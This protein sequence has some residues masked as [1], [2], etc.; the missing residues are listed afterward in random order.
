MKSRL[1]ATMA[2]AVALGLA[3]ETRAQSGP[4]GSEADGRADLRTLLGDCPRELLREAWDD[5]EALETA[6]VEVEV[7]T[8]CTERAEAIARLLDAQ[9]RLDGALAV[10]R[11]TVPTPSAVLATV[12]DDRVERLRDEIVSL[13]DRI[14]RLEGE[15]EGAETESTLAELRGDLATAEADLARMEEADAAASASPADLLPPG[16]DGAETGISPPTGATPP[17]MSDG[18]ETVDDVP[19]PVM[20]P[21]SE[22]PT[23]AAADVLSDSLPPPG[24]GQTGARLGELSSSLS[25][26]DLESSP[27]SSEAPPAT[28]AGDGWPR[29]GRTEWR[30]IH[31]VRNGDGPWEVLLQGSRE[32][33]IPVPGATRDD[34]PTFHWQ[35]VLDRPV[36]LSVG[37]RRDD[38]LTLLEVAREGVWIDDPASPDGTPVLVPFR[39]HESVA[40]GTA[41]WEFSTVEE[42]G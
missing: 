29:D 8:I 34:S 26:Q 2:F 15:P 7:L 40:A 12:A 39:T 37:E 18:S 13:R 24:T 14:A 19:P 36:T 3:P 20:P 32:I 33:A 35:P 23:Q 25:R 16:S 6:A 5:M 17:V 30:V 9:G 1:A 10:Q 28:A 22:S 4:P 27:P 11:A 42:D 38:G 31:A 41:A 21:G